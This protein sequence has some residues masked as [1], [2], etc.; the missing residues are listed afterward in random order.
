MNQLE[1]LAALVERTQSLPEAERLRMPSGWTKSNDKWEKIAWAWSDNY[2]SVRTHSY[3]YDPDPL[4]LEAA[5]G[6]L[7]EWLVL[8][9]Y[10][11]DRLT[12]DDWRAYDTGDCPDVLPGTGGNTTM[13][14]AQLAAEA[15]LGVGR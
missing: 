10:Y 12:P 6:V 3:D 14:D 8:R 5:S 4:D 15:V 2:G 9:G 1:R 11:T 7:A 13:L